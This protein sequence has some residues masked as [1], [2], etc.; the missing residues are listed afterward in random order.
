[1]LSVQP[2]VI[3]IN[4]P[5]FVVGDIH[6]QFDDLLQIFEMG[7][8]I[9][10][11]IAITI[12]ISINSWQHCHLSNLLAAG[13][14]PYSNFLFLGN[15]LNKGVFD[16]EVITLLLALLVKYSLDIYCHANSH[17]GDGDGDGCDHGD[18]GDGDGYVMV[19]V[20]VMV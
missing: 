6:G 8:R 19:M 1:M 18:D 20:M 16:I 2:N 4:S 15:Y 3:S 10:C 12:I 9:A 11:A 14:P 17:D 13:E 7:M 5:V